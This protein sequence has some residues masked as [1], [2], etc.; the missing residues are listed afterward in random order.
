MKL[1]RPTRAGTMPTAIS[2]KLMNGNAA[3]DRSR[4]TRLCRMARLCGPAT[5]NPTYSAAQ[6]RTVTPPSAGMCWS[7]QRM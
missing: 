6:G 1:T 4:A 2:A 5:E 3:P 7:N